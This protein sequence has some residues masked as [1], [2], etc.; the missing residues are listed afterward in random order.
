MN[1]P[2]TI[3]ILGVLHTVE[4]RPFNENDAED[5]EASGSYKDDGRI[6][7]IDSAQPRYLHPDIFVH[8]VAEG[9]NSLLDLGLKHWQIC[10]MAAGFHDVFW[11]QMMSDCL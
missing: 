5:C 8:E 11:N 10:G 2:D 3:Y 4:I 7:A 9:I 6:I 1:I